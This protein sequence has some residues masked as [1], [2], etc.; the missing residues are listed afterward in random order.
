MNCGVTVGGRVVEEGVGVA[1][2]GATDT[3][4][5]ERVG[6]VAGLTPHALT[7]TMDRTKQRLGKIPIRLIGRKLSA[8]TACLRLYLPHL[9]RSLLYIQLVP[10]LL[11]K[12]RNEPQPHHATALAPFTGRRY[13]A[14]GPRS[15]RWPR[16][17]GQAPGG[18]WPATTYVCKTPRGV[19]PAPDHACEIS[20]GRVP[21]R[22]S[23]RQEP[24]PRP[25]GPPR[26]LRPNPG[27]ASCPRLT[28]LA[29]PFAS[30]ALF[31]SASR[32]PTAAPAHP[33]P[34][35]HS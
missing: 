23:T 19:R 22:F 27:A 10:A 24:P 15:A 13:V 11:S 16:L 31:V 28:Q 33:P 21:R 32:P 35:K 18:V 9:S 14:R 26:S 3:I 20:R 2:A 7:S 8:V 30:A 6:M 17:W 34:H 25:I 5:A 12:P 4:A 29:Y 1:A